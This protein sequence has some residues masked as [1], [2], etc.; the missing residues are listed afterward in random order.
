MTR[1]IIDGNNVFG[2]RPDGWWNDRPR[3]QARL[4]QR[5]AL[6]CR[7]HDEAVML[8]F[9]APLSPGAAELAGGNLE[10]V[11]APRRGRN[12]ADDHIVDLTA[13]ADASPPTT[14]VTSDRGPAGRASPGD[15]AVDGSRSVPRSR[16]RY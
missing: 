1:W 13:S 11:E 16:S 12:A 7:T 15:V 9:D 4:A 2:S 5:V 10:I 14:V 3:A 8:V 6:W